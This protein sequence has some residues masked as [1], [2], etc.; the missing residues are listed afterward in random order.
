MPAERG[1]Q[2]RLVIEMRAGQRLLVN[3]AEIQ[4]R[5]RTSVLLCNRVRFLFGRQILDAAEATTPARLLYL[6]L[7]TA[8]AGDEAQREGGAE[9]AR[10]MARE[11]MPARSPEGRAIL[12]AAMAE[13]A[14]D[15]GR[16]ALLLVRRLFAE[17]DAAGTPPAGTQ[18]A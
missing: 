13:L 15:R 14:A 6:A 17:D 12:Q 7:Q 11:Q 18:A 16:A 5:S 3:G 8:Y 1:A 2:G 10:R 4:F 9:A